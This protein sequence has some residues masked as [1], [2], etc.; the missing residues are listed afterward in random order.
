[1]TD[2]RFDITDDP[3]DWIRIDGF[4]IAKV[5]LICVIEAIRQQARDID[6][7]RYA[8]D[9]CVPA[10]QI[11]LDAAQVISVFGDDRGATIRC[12]LTEARA[13]LAKVGA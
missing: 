4:P 2:E 12:A 7:L 5:P 10:L 3:V 13:A 9:E 11:G 1:M 6:A 8:L